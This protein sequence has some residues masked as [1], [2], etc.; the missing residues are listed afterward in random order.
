MPRARPTLTGAPAQP[1][2]CGQQ[3]PDEPLHTT[4]HRSSTTPRSSP[5]AGPRRPLPPNR[6]PGRQAALRL[7]YNTEY[8]PCADRLLMPTEIR[9]TTANSRRGHRL[10]MHEDIPGRYL[11]PLTGSARVNPGYSSSGTPDFQVSRRSRTVTDRRL[12]LRRQ[13][14]MI[15]RSNPSPHASPR[16]TAA[17]WATENGPAPS[18]TSSAPPP[19]S[20]R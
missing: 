15:K 7:L 2:D 12:C 6:T 1:Q 11:L 13:D 20:K 4:H 17:T 16:R 18:W 8:P 10:A 5:P 3:R 19:R 9:A 14:S